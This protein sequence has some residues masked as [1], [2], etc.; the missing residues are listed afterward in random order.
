M[1]ES[2]SMLL[3]VIT[4]LTSSMLQK[5]LLEQGMVSVDR[6][7]LDLESGTCD[8]GGQAD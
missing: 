4:I 6:W 1:V 8:N 7:L 3:V 5:S 2:G